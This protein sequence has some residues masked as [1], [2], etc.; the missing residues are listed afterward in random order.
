MSAKLRGL[1]YDAP[2]SASDADRAF[3]GGIPELYDSLLGP[4]L[5]E[6][7]AQ[8]VAERFAG[9]EGRLLEIAAGTGRVTR[10]LAE[11]MAPD[12]RIV[13]T[14]LNAPMLDY[15]RQVV[16]S[17]KVSW[18]EADAQALPFQDASFDAAV[19]QFGVMFF[20]D[21][22]LALREARR[23]LRNGGR[24]AFTVWDRL[25]TNDLSWVTQGALTELFPDDPPS[26]L[27]RVPFGFNDHDEFRRLLS[28]AGFGGVT[29]NT[30]RLRTPISSVR[31]AVSGLC[32]G[33]PLRAEIEAH[34][35][36]ALN[37]AVEAVSGAVARRFGSARP[38]AM[39]QALLVEARAA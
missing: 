1:C 3:T 26:F 13:A 6:P 38:D 7:F 19:I 30:L 22:R 32:L 31:D 18:R 4:M 2:M 37:Q 33:S 29:I 14:D 16:S 11:T 12:A 34:G 28:E 35:E 8:A 24:L 20:P 25:E 23:V 5:F 36:G 9:F 21:K 17:P 27:R 10:V 39:G 15:G